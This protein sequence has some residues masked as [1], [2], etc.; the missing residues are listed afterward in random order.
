M[1]TV[2]AGLIALLHNGGLPS[3]YKLAWKIYEDVRLQINEVLETGLVRS[4]CSVDEVIEW[5]F[6]L[7]TDARGKIEGDGKRAGKV[8][9]AVG[10]V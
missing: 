4:E 6:Q 5:S 2:I 10:F 7:Y 9:G 8:G 3:K 1:N